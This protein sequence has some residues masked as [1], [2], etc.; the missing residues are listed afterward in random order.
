VKVLRWGGAVGDPDVALG[1]QVKKASH[2]GARML[3]TLT[4]VSV[5][6]QQGEAS[7]ETPLG[8]PGGYELIDDNLRRVDEVA[9]LRLP[10]DQ[11][12]GSRHAVAI[13]ETERTHL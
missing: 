3:R 5:G 9:E 11:G 13:L 1:R 8:Q 10:E 7:R 4:L 2:A 12:L 6:Q